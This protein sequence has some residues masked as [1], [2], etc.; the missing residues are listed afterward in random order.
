[1]NN[2]WNLVELKNTDIYKLHAFEELLLELIQTKKITN[3]ILLS[4]VNPSI[5]I[6]AKQNYFLDVDVMS[7]ERDRIDVTRRNTGGRSMYLDNGHLIISILRNDHEHLNVEKTYTEALNLI[8]G[9]L[10]H[11]THKKFYIRDRDDLMVDD[12]KIGGASQKNSAEYSMVHCYIRVDDDIS[13]MLKY[14]MIDGHHL[15]EYTQ[16]L[17]KHVTSIEDIANTRNDTFYNRFKDRLLSNIHYKKFDP[18]PYS[19]ALESKILK[20]KDLNHIVGQSDYPSKG[21][22]DIIMGSGTKAKLLIPSLEGKVK[23]S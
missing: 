21:N 16:E 5:S 4:T 6:S 2:E 22:C 23:Y 15:G 17:K 1:M 14:V 10:E 13:K 3:T 7:C 9:T 12:K 8:S 20:Y 11:L 18:T 19:D